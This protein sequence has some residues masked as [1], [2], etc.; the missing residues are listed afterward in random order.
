MIRPPEYL[1][2]GRWVAAPADTDTFAIFS[3][4]AHSLEPS[5][6]SNDRVTFECDRQECNSGIG[7]DVILPLTGDKRQFMAPVTLQGRVLVGSAAAYCIANIAWWLQPSLIHEVMAR[8]DVGEA[9]GGLV[10]SVEMTTIALSAALFGKLLDK[11]SLLRIATIGAVVTLSGAAWSMTIQDYDLLLISRPITG[12][13]EGA[14]LAAASASLANF[15]EPDRAY[16]IINIAAILFCSAAVFSLPLTAG[17]FNL[18]YIVFPTIFACIAVLSLL[19]PL[20]S[21]T[22][23]QGRVR[24]TPAALPAHGIFSLKLVTL[25]IA[26]FIV[27]LGAGAM[28][29]FYYLLGDMAGLGEGE[30]HNAVGMAALVSVFGALSATVVGARFG[31]LL[32]LT[33]G[34]LILIVAINAM[35]HWHHPLAFRLGAAFNVVG[36]YFLVPYFLGYAA[37]QDPSGRDAAITAGAF[38]LTGAVGPYLGGYIIENFGAGSMGWIVLIANSFSWY[39]F[40]TIDRSLKKDAA[41]P[42]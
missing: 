26:V 33:L 12:F 10:A 17:Y 7:Y 25:V 28:W 38:L 21:G 34:I 30:I 36:M 39:L 24:S 2:P 20:L 4:I 37:D 19:I 5:I 31:R 42:V 6:Q 23:D 27:S 13:G 32:P 8:Y 9:A 18:E 3:I 40:L 14:M 29:S 41:R 16:G 35:S 15:R 22:A 1:A 11:L